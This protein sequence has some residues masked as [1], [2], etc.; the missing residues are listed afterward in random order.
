MNFQDKLLEYFK[1][2][3]LLRN[4][5]TGIVLALIIVLPFWYFGFKDSLT[6]DGLLNWKFGAIVILITIS[7]TLATKETKTRAFDDK[8]L[9]DDELQN[10]QQ[11]IESQSKEIKKKDPRSKRSINF[12]TKYNKDQQQMYNEIKT[13]AK[14]EEYEKLVLKYR[15][16]KKEKKAQYYEKKIAHLKQNPLFDKHFEPY[17]L[18]NIIMIQK[19]L[20]KLPKKKGNT[21]INNNPKQLNWFMTVLS[22][23][24]RSLGVGVFG[25]I[26]FVI[27]ESIGSILAFYV[28]YILVLAFTI[29]TQYL[30]TTWKIDNKYKL[31]LE[32]IDSIQTE[33]LEYLE[34]P[35][36]QTINFKQ[37]ECKAILDFK[38]NLQPT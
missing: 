22:M 3:E 6:V 5:R 21:E 20:G 17:D 15:L 10:T 26:P 12:I 8:F 28:S 25:A 27:N 13:N 4:I 24:V 38:A 9:I 7:V 11:K 14:I 1:D 32:K 36:E 30:L 16:N 29:I 35:Q 23:G 2:K 19:T 34:Q 37:K 31:G 33:L 18:R